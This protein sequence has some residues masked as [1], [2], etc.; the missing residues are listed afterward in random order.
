[1]SP[2]IRP[3]IAGL[4]APGLLWLA[5]SVASG[6]AAPAPQGL[7]N[8]APTSPATY[9]ALL[10][11]SGQV[12]RGEIV[13]DAAAGSYRLRANGGPVSYPRTMVQKAAGS[14][15]E[16]YQFQ[17]ARLPVGDPDERIKL[18]RWCLTEHLPAQARE[19]LE[20]LKKMCPGDV[21]VERMLYNIASS[22]VDRPA[23]DPELRRTSAET[24]RDDSPRTLDPRAMARVVRHFNALPQIFDLS[25]A[26]A[27]VR[28]NEFASFVQPVVLRNCVKCHDEKYDGSFQLVGI[29]NQRDL[30][31]P[32]IARANLDATLR[33]VNPDDPTRSELL[34]AGLVPHGGS[35]NA[36]FRGPNDPPYTILLT[37]VKS[38]RPTCAAG[39]RRARAIPALR[40]GFST[41]ESMPGDGFATDR[42]GRA[43]G[44][45][46]LPV[47]PR[48]PAGYKPRG[49]PSF[50]AW[51]S[52]SEPLADAAAVA[53]SGPLG[54]PEHRGKR[55]VPHLA[56]RQS[57]VPDTRSR[58]RRNDTD[59]R[60]PLR[61]SRPGREPPKPSPQGGEPGRSPGSP[62]KPTGAV[63]TAIPNGPNTVV[64]GPTDDP[65]L[66]PG[67]SQPLYPNSPKADPDADGDDTKVDPASRRQPKKI[68][69]NAR[70]ERLM[71]NRNGAPRAPDEES[72]Q[73]PGTIRPPVNR[74]SLGPP[75]S[76]NRAYLPDSG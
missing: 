30:V 74:S 11:S 39:A 25:Q 76:R 73:S 49:S 36:I 27:I 2:Q 50:P 16:L 67:M 21:E 60:P 66:L 31:N 59:P 43:T 42:S 3:L 26:Q 17:V 24:T 34:S 12:V 35:K 71:K 23:I 70:L 18:A 61:P 4:A 54:R 40:P 22:T 69:N 46:E 57:A 7:P 19:Q 64:V 13:E 29:K 14:V 33:L 6:Q 62:S 1:M 68:D 28:A 65:N 48:S 45:G 56:G 44:R 72:V 53:P 5:T 32:D 8:P 10:L 75:P 58:D 20:I 63:K 37:W 51:N 47:T 52:P 41:P 15:A 9:R 55:H 38:L